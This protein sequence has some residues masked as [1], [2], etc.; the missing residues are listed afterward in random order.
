MFILWVII[1]CSTACIS[2]NLPDTSLNALYNFSA[3]SGLSEA[4]DVNYLIAE[5]TIDSV[6]CEAVLNFEEDLV[7]DLE[8]S[9]EDY[10]D[11][12]LIDYIQQLKKCQI[13]NG[14][15]VALNTRLFKKN[16]NVTRYSQGSNN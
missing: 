9:D 7:F 15:I 8:D 6:D 12:D 10:Y 4:V 3:I 14:N 1:Q 13:C 16:C 11:S 5:N 2:T